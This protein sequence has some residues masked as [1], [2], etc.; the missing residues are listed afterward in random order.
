MEDSITAA[1]TLENSTRH[2]NST[3]EDVRDSSDNEGHT[4]NDD[5]NGGVV[6]IRPIIETTTPTRRP[7]DTL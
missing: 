2:Y 3:S 5:T 4:G 1:A 6:P 7:D